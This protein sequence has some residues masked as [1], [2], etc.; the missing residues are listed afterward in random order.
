[1]LKKTLSICIVLVITAV[2]F[3]AVFVIVRS[4][5]TDEYANWQVVSRLLNRPADTRVARG[6][7]AGAKSGGITPIGLA[8][9]A[10]PAV[11]QARTLVDYLAAIG[12]DTS[13]AHRAVLAAERGI[14]RYVGSSGQNIRLLEL[15]RSTPPA[16][17]A[18]GL[19]FGQ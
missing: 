10:E 6:E 3:Q 15:L 18:R 5:A 4:A 2:V 1:M 13:F 14:E 9:A 7:E 17:G 12:A 11:A 16:G 19:Q 8:R